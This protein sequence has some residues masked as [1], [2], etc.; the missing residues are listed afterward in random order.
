MTTGQAAQRTLAEADA[1]AEFDA[2]VVGAGFAGIYMLHRLRGLG[3]TARV[4]EA[5]TDVG[6]TWYWNRYPGARCDIE[7]LSYQYSFD[8]SIQREWNWSER[9]ATQPEILEYANFVA[10]KFDLRRDMQFETRVTAATYDDASERW[11]VETDRGDRYS[12]RFCIMATGCLSMS[13]LPEIPGRDRFEGESYHTGQWPHEG[14]D[15]SGKR[16]GVIGTGSSGI[17]SIPLIAEQ[18]DHV[19]VFQRTPNFSIPAH[20]HPLTPEQLASNK[21]EFQ[22]LRHEAERM[23]PARAGGQLEIPKAFDLSDEERAQRYEQLWE[24]GGVAFLGAAADLL[25][26]ERANETAANFV[27]GK[28]QEIVRDPEVAGVLSPDDHPLGTKR[29]CVDTGYY[30]T[31]NRENT[32]LINL[33]D[34]PIEEIT[35]SGVRTTAED[36]EFDAIVYATGFDAMT[37]ALLA[38]DIRGRNGVSLRDE[39][40]G[41]PKTYLGLQVV[42][43]PN[44]FT[45]TGPGSPSVLSNMLISIEQHVDWIS[46]CLEFM[47]QGDLCTIEAT[48]EAQD[49]WVAHVNEVGDRTLFPRAN[50]W[51]V[52]ANIPGKPRVFMPY[53]AGVGPYREKCDEVA[54]N[55]YE[56]FVLDAPRTAAP[57]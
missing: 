44:L 42:G 26:D 36:F 27:R 46:D 56:G 6:G 52:G 15:F 50:S 43:F 32:A 24:I 13:R 8:D 11:T 30:Q 34:T 35:H 2:V 55:G 20:N 12:A 39:W 48:P 1:L 51:Y 4:I 16:V 5:G 9:Y 29:I 3:F 37:G 40:A 57:A 53:V 23:A 18:A 33:R 7:S 14:V 31:Y 41:G 10:D 45:I 38:M 49:A 47:R 22:A 54:A 25:I 19:T 21:E 28:I 17:Q